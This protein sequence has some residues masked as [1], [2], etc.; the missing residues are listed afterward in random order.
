[1]SDQIQ[2]RNRAR[3]LQERQLP[4]AISHQKAL[5]KKMDA[6]NRPHMDINITGGGYVIKCS[7][8]YYELIRSNLQQYFDTQTNL[9]VKSYV[10]QVDSTGAQQDSSFKLVYRNGQTCSTINLYHTTSTIMVNG[11]SQDSF[12]KNH[13]S[14]FHKYI[15]QKLLDYRINLDDINKT[16]YD[17]IQL[18]ANPVAGPQTVKLAI[19]SASHPP[20]HEEEDMNCPICEKPA[21]G[22]TV[23]CDTCLL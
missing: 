21:Q 18:V 5:S 7:T 2:V 6:C 3:G 23:F 1:M 4:Y 20:Q 17:S 8:A 10:D 15:Q 11:K 19:S 9:K 13:F 16:L 22:D 12:V 14:K